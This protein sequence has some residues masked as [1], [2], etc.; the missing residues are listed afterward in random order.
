MI[1]EEG[2]LYFWTGTVLAVVNAVIVA[3]VVGAGVGPFNAWQTA[4][5][6][7]GGTLVAAL[8]FLWRRWATQWT[9][10]YFDLYDVV[11][12]PMVLTILGGIAASAAQ[13]G[14][15]VQDGS[16]NWLWAPVVLQFLGLTQ[17]LALGDYPP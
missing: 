17:I 11:E 2:L 12:F 9:D 5:V 6:V 16:T 3:L 13:V 8:L 4:L 15:A 10:T 1:T 14:G 7:G